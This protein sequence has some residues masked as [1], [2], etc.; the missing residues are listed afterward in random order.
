MQK[1]PNKLKKPWLSSSSPIDRTL[2]RCYHSGPEWTCERWQWRGTPHSLR[3][4][5]Y[6]DLIN[7][8]LMSY[9]G[10]TWGGVLPLCREAVGVFY[11]PSQLSNNVI[12]FLKPYN[13]GQGNDYYW[14]V[15]I[16]WDQSLLDTDACN[17][18]ILW[19]VFVVDWKTSYRKTV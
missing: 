10:Y 12:S 5:H 13:C 9:P 1:T 6:W 16:T 11:S 3:L 17:N 8:L 15:S 19:K 18:P 4:Q 14:I 7:K 2:I